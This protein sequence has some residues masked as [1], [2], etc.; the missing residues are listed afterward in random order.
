[1]VS[2]NWPRDARDAGPFKANLKCCTYEPFLP[3]FSI[4]RILKQ[5]TNLKRLEEAIRKGRLTP[6]GLLPGTSESQ[7][8]GRDDVIRCSFLSGGEPAEAASGTAVQC[9]IWQER[10]SVCRSY[11]CVSDRGADGQ[12]RWKDAEEQ[13]N[14]LEWTLAHEVAWDLGFTQTEIERSDWAEW[15]TRK[16]EFFEKCAERAFGELFIPASDV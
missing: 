13:G 4:G 12:R 14:R 5:E 8:F 6:L 10:P 1:M 9:S 2:Q 15:S 7:D 3:N 11:F 16:F